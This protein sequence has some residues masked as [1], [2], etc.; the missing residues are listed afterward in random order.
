MVAK[1]KITGLIL[2]FLLSFTVRAVVGLKTLPFSQDQARDASLMRD[3]KASGSSWVSLGPKTSIG[4]FYLPPLYYQIDYWLSELT[5]FNPFVMMWFGIIIESFTPCLI[6]LLLLELIDSKIALLT[7]ATYALSPFVVPY[8][9]ASWNPSTIPFFTTLALYTA[10]MYVFHHRRAYL[11]LYFIAIAVAAQFHFQSAVLV[12]SG[13]LLL[14]SLIQRRQDLRFIGVGLAI[15]ILSLSSYFFGEVKHN[16]ENSRSI[17]D[18]FTSEHSHIYA[19][20]S[21]TEYLF[22]FLP[23]F[24]DRVFLKINTPFRLLGYITFFGGQIALL[25]L[26]LRKNKKALWILVYFWFIVIMSRLYKGDK[27]DF[28]LSF[29][30]VWPYVFLGL[31]I[32]SIKV[33]G[34]LKQ[35]VIV[36]M[37]CLMLWQWNQTPILNQYRQYQA[38]A[39]AVLNLA[40]TD[41]INLVYENIDNKIP[42][43]FFLANRNLLMSG[44]ALKTVRV[45]DSS[46]CELGE[47]YQLITTNRVGNFELV[48]GQKK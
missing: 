20:L 22:S 7:A 30:F 26:S 13:L 37:G 8:A 11:V 28:Y 23:D 47:D 25:L 33:F 44:S 46:K 32:H 38:V 2:L 17:I 5:N 35:I 16:W 12:G 34:W 31:I 36:A 43:N 41:E 18:Y 29:L 9:I 39:D 3:I 45:C 40:G 15:V 24:F 27:L 48:L 42:V 1:Q 4:D 6:F 14:V 21:K 19:R 10:F